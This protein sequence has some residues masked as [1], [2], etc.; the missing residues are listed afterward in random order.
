MSSQ[1][2]FPGEYQYLAIKMSTR[3]SYRVIEIPKEP[4]FPTTVDWL[5][6]V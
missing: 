5:D 2:D 3:A 6:K 4:K 1:F